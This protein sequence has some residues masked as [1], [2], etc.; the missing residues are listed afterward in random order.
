MGI[1]DI[2]VTMKIKDHYIYLKLSYETIFL[3]TVIGT[4]NRFFH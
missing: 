2:I 1:C 3:D 4:K